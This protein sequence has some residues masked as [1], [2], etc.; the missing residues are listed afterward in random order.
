MGE[1]NDAGVPRVEQALAALYAAPVPEPAFVAQLEEQLA[2]RTQR[3]ARTAASS[4]SSSLQKFWRGLH[5]G[6]RWGLA[7]AGLILLLDLALA[8]AGPQRVLAS[9]E[10]LLG[11]VPGIGFVDLESTRVLVDPVAVTRDGL[12]L[13]VE[14]VI[15]GPDRTEV[16]IRSEGLPPEDELWP[17]GARQEVDFEPL[18]RLP[19]GQALSTSTWTL[20][21]GG[22]TLEFPSL[23]DGVD[24]VTLE[25]ASLPLVPADAAPEDWRVPL[26]LHPV[27]EDVVADLFTEPYAPAGAEDMHQGITLR[28]LEVAHSPEETVLRLQ[29]Q[30]ADPDW[31]SPTIGDIRMPELRDDVGHMYHGAVASSSGS[32][33]ST[34]VI[35]IPDPS[36]ITPM[37]TPDVPTHERVEAFAPISAL[38]GQLTLWVDGMSFHVPTDASFVVDLGDDPQVGDRWPLDLDLTVAGFPVH[39]SAARLTQEDQQ[40]DGQP[41]KQTFL[42]FDVDPVPD[43]EGRTLHGFG[44]VGDERWFDGT[45]GGYQPQSRAMQTGL[46]LRDEAGIPR[47]PIELRVDGAGV[48]FRGP[49]ILTWSIPRSGRA[50]DAQAVPVVRHPAK[51]A[52]T[53]QGLTLRA[54]Q[55]VETDRLTAVTVELDDPPAGFALNRV[56]SWNP[57][58]Q[59]SDLYL[60][61]DR[62]RRYELAKGTSWLPGGDQSPAIPGPQISATLSFEPLS[63]LARRA[64]LHVPT[65]DLFITDHVSFDVTVPEG[66]EMQVRDDAPWPV[67]EPWSVD[68]AIEVEGYQLRLSQAQLAE[69]RYATL[70]WLM[71]APPEGGR[72]SRWL[73][74]LRPTSILAPDG[75]ALDLSSAFLIDDSSL[76]FD[77]ATGG[78]AVLPGRYHFEVEGVTAAVTGPWEVSWDLH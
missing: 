65:L 73:S 55:V 41:K 61:D 75:Q 2:A 5:R 17:G 78:S 77:L 67:S 19:D 51:A 9:L 18:L 27:T 59:S 3:E 20:R 54:S 32:S 64:T 44:L 68:I 37:P 50:E 36:Q 42:V 48:A 25:L 34:E 16:V 49:W 74:G 24:R 66:L 53:Q 63:P 56:L 46:K 39:I 76:S 21:L 6:H 13:R 33:V 14:Q 15:A 4:R 12:T 40:A 35:R 58:T 1:Q 23:P 30:W 60:T 72:A 31:R 29:V 38:A 43:R 62:G 70:L 22:G 52:E 8:I 71:A 11:Y 10:G 26:D 7:A 57:A 28:V 69:T 45:T 47:G